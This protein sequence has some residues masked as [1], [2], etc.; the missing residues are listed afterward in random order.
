ML[1]GSTVALVFGPDPVAEEGCQEHDHGEAQARRERGQQ[2]TE[3]LSK[4][5]CKR[6]KN[7]QSQ[8]EEGETRV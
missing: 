1:A 3:G 6:A 5:T 8:S 7:V 2:E 4:R